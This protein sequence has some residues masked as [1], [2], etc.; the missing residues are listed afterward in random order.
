MKPFFI[1]RQIPWD[2][3]LCG[4]SVELM[5]L[6]GLDRNDLQQR[7]LHYDC[8]L[9][10]GPGQIAL[11]AGPSGSGKTL[12]LKE[13]YNCVHKS[14]RIWI[15][16]IPLKTSKSVIDCMQGPFDQTPRCLC[17]MGLAEVFTLLSSPARLSEG[18]RYRYRLARAWLSGKQYL[19]ADEFGSALD[20]PGAAVFA[21]QIR[22][23][24]SQSRLIFIAASCREE[25]AEPLRPDVIIRADR[26]VS[27]INK[28]IL[29]TR[30]KKTG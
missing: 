22:R 13:S 14:Q 24:I 6:F 15:N 3:P 29:P 23:L 8:R 12:L 10:I 26:A 20:E 4:R 30:K 9:S 7:I 1:S 18:Q 17:R 19:F 16:R 5:R 11:I 2:Q 27:C 21:A 28:T 25:L